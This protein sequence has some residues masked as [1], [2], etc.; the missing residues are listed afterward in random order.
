MSHLPGTEGI[1]FKFADD[2]T[3]AYR[4]NYLAEY[5]QMLTEDLTIL[6]TYFQKWRLKPHPDKT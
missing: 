3:I 1:K 6:N 5:D 4:F 2:I